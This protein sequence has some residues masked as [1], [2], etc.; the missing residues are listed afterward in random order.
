MRLKRLFSSKLTQLTTCNLGGCFGN[1][2]WDSNSESISRQE[3]NANNRVVFKFRYAE[4]L[5]ILLASGKEG[6]T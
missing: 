2:R 5:S 1:S 6:H 4:K 3:V